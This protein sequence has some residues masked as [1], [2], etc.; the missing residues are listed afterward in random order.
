MPKFI[1]SSVTD[2]V[3]HTLFLRQVRKG[4]DEK[5]VYGIEE[6]ADGDK[7]VVFHLIDQ[8]TEEKEVCMVSAKFILEFYGKKTEDE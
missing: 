5:C 1:E 7:N 8:L 4:F 6:T 2:L 3:Q